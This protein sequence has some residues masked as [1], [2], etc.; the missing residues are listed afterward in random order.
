[1]VF[2]W[3]S[4]Q[5]TPKLILPSVRLLKQLSKG[6]F[7]SQGEVDMSYDCQS[8][9]LTISGKNV[10]L[11]IDEV[12]LSSKLEFRNGEMLGVTEDRAVAKTILS[13]MVRSIAGRYSCS[14]TS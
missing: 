7:P 9:A 12:Y 3:Y 14:C 6:F 13:Y 4:L 10:V 11:L 5:K 2:E 8:T 1:M